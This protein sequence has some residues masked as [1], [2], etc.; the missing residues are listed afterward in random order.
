MPVLAG[1]E[2]MCFPCE[3]FWMVVGMVIVQNGEL[4]E[5]RAQKRSG[6]E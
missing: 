3:A 4:K 6:T 5:V 2:Y 1:R